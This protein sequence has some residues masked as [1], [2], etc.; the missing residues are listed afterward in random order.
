ML[1]G[2]SNSIFKCPS[3]FTFIIFFIFFKNLCLSGFCHFRKCYR[4][5]DP[6]KAGQ[7]QFARFHRI[8]EISEGT[9]V[10]STGPQSDFLNLQ[11][12]NIEANSE[13]K[14]KTEFCKAHYFSPSWLNIWDVNKTIQTL[15]MTC[16]IEIQLKGFAI[17]KVRCTNIFLN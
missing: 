5:V 4:Y 10:S 12:T 14:T 9:N 1:L 8:V 6:Q 15:W 3:S 13:V 7:N 16:C 2:T 11:L 17:D